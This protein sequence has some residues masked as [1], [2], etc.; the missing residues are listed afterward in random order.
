M[1]GPKFGG[2]FAGI[3]V[4]RLAVAGAA[5]AVGAF[6]DDFI[7]EIFG[8]VAIAA[9]AGEFVV[10]RRG[11]HLRN[12]RVHVQAFEFVAVGGERIEELLFVEALRDLE[13]VLLAGHGVEIAEHFAHASEFG[14]KHALHVFVAERL[15]IAIDPGRHFLDHVES[16]LVAAVDV[17]VEQAGHDFVDGVEGSPDLLA[18]AQAIEEFDRESAQIAALQCGLAL[19]EFGDDGVGVVLEVFIPARGIHQRASGQIVAAGVVAA[20]FAVRRF[21]SAQ[22]LR[23]RGEC[24][25]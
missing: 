16:L 11:D 8:D 25:R 19:A 15:G 17:H 4:P 6:A 5:G 10:A 18:L 14:A 13:I 9:F 7:P 22:R 3:G 2:E 1:S 24:Q 20:K 21:P 12:V 23:G